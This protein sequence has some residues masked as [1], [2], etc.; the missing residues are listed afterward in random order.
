M[1]TKGGVR[2]SS[3]CIIFFL[4]IN[5]QMSEGFY[6]KIRKGSALGAGALSVGLGSL[7]LAFAMR[8][9]SS[10]DLVGLVGY[11]GGPDIDLGSSIVFK[12][13]E[14]LAGIGG[15]TIFLLGVLLLLSTSRNK[16]LE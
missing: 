7:S 6:N 12:G 9:K 1:L 10:D 5:I 13:T 15:A 4:C 8:E 11:K 16:N 14:A 2:I 3:L